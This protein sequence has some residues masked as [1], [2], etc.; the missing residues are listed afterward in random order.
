[1]FRLFVVFLLLSVATQAQNNFL[2][3][4]KLDTIFGKPRILSYDLIDRVQIEVNKKKET[5]TALQ[6]LSVTIDSQVY[7]PIQYENKILLMK[8]LKSGYLSLYAF[9]IENQ[10]SFDGR[11]LTKLDGT[12]MEVPNLSFKRFMENFLKD[13]SSIVSKI[14]NGDFSKKELDKIVDEYNECI[15]NANKDKVLPSSEVNEKS[16]A[17]TTLIGKVEAQDF[18]SKKDALDLLRDI[19]SRVNK[20]ESIPNYLTDGLKGYLAG[21]PVLTEDLNAL[22]LLLQK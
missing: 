13:C 16:V 10:N 8:M 19:Q 6:V 22:L 9:R 20:N 3:T 5:F 14:K 18:T 21:V 2:V 4:S 7:K 17:I 1:M 12:S 15:A 11:F